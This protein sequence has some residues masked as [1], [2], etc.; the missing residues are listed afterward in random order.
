MFC[1]RHEVLRVDEPGSCQSPVL[2]ILYRYSHKNSGIVGYTAMLGHTSPPTR[3]GASACCDMLTSSIHEAFGVH[4]P[5][6]VNNVAMG[7]AQASLDS[8]RP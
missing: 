4:T 7:P 8:P 5:M 6:M 1:Y 2:P 3:L